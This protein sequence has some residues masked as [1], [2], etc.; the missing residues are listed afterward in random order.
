MG[1]YKLLGCKILEREIASIV[2]NCTASPELITKE[3][4]LVVEK[5][6]IIDLKNKKDKIV[7]TI[8]TNKSSF[9]CPYCS[10]PS[11]KIHSYYYR[12][13][14]DLPIMNKQS[15]LIIKSRKSGYTLLSGVI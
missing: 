15:F 1:R 13:V 10:Q 11:S 12:E 8:S 7:F 14:Q 4:G 6:N 2:Y 9:I 3:T 5:N